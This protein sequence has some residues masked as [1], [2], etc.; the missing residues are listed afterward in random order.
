[1]TAKTM[2]LKMYYEQDE[3]D[4]LESLLESMRTYM[5]RKKVIG[6]HKTNYKNFIRYTK[7]LLKVNPYN[8]LLVE[9]LRKEIETT[10]PLTEQEWLLR[11]LGQL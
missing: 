11:Q 9:R 6:Y 2:L 8:K 7:K 3:L 4:A 10:N 5:Q 1:M